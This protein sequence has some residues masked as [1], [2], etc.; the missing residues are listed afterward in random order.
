VLPSFRTPALDDAFTA[1]IMV[2]GAIAWICRHGRLHPNPS[3]P[4][5]FLHAVPLSQAAMQCES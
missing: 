5:L 1:V 4:R 3:P 2:A